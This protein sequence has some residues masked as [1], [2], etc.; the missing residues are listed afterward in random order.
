MRD[1]LHM[2]AKETAYS[3]QALQCRTFNENLCLKKLPRPLLQLLVSEWVGFNAS[4]KLNCEELWNIGCK[5]RGGE[6]EEA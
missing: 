2:E 6:S 4:E 3:F 1:F 5:W